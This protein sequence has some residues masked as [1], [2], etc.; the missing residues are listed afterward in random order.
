MSAGDSGHTRGG[1]APA[2]SLGPGDPP[3]TPR[4]ARSLDDRLAG[5]NAGSTV[6]RCFQSM[7]ASLIAW[8]RRNHSPIRLILP[9]RPGPQQGKRT[10]PAPHVRCCHPLDLHRQRRRPGLICFCPWRALRLPTDTATFTADHRSSRMR[11]LIA[12]IPVIVVVL[13]ASFPSAAP[14][15]PAMDPPATDPEPSADPGQ[16]PG[17]QVDA[18]GR[19]M[20][21]QVLTASAFTSPAAARRRRATPTRPTQASPASGPESRRHDGVPI[22]QAADA[23]SRRSRARLTPEAVLPWRAGPWPAVAGRR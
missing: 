12:A 5:Q 21:S 2:S 20:S 16:R 7:C 14:Q 19:S 9:G 3:R 6:I 4:N 13:V 11:T 22:D 23:I 15:P 18:D 10:V 1:S 17:L 8:H